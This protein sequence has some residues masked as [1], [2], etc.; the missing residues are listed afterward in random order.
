[1]VIHEAAWLTTGG[2]SHFH[3]S[4]SNLIH[5]AICGHAVKIS[6]IIF[7]GAEK[8]NCQLEEFVVVSL[9]YIHIFKLKLVIKFKS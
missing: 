4:L 6:L 7:S 5:I 9:S 2:E 1:M 8:W 3:L